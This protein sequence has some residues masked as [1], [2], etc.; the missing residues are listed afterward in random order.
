M[1][2]AIIGTGNVGSALGG[3][4]TR[5]G[6]DVTLAGQD[7]TKA[8][9]VA[10]KLGATVAVDAVMAARGA[11]VI[12]LA[13]P[14][15]AAEAVAAQI[16]DAV[17][18]KVVIDATNPLKPDYS[19][20][21]TEGES[22]GAERIAS[23]LPGAKVVKAFNTLFAGLQADPA[24]TGI[25]PDGLLAGDDD[26]AKQV[27]AELARS[28]GLRPVDLGPLANAGALEAMAWLNI[29]LQLRTGGAWNSA[30][31][32]VNAPDRAIAA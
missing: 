16:A 22:S 6:H 15:S 31:V 28:I 13:V 2:I 11:D 18:G 26:A 10:A 1:R 4:F 24:S 3:S 32:L 27:V 8:G 20:L 19:G 14:F 12:V 29:A 9:A 25:T 5:A 17:A 7:E 23:R 30:F 21:A